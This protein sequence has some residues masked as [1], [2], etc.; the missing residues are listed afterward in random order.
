MLPAG[1]NSDPVH[2][3]MNLDKC[4]PNRPLSVG[5]LLDPFAAE[6]HLDLVMRIILGISEMTL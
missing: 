2:N 5:T 6:H 1:R 4:Q 3:L